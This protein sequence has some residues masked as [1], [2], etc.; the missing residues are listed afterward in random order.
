MNRPYTLEVSIGTK[1]KALR[2][3]A[4]MTQIQLAQAAGILQGV[5]T[6]YETDKKTPSAPRLAA[7][8]RALGTTVEDLLD[9]AQ[10]VTPPTATKPHIHGNSRE[11]KVQELF[12][13]LDEE[14]QRVVLKQI[15][16]MINDQTDKKRPKAA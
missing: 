7:I 9:D 8:A 1:I 14:A 10:P 13:Q 15:K 3:K 2:L 12:R 6:R 11:A 5:L 16:A 4:G